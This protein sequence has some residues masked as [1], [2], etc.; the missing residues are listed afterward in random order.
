MAPAA[1][2]AGPAQK[3]TPE[4]RE[5]PVAHDRE[6]EQTEA[7]RVQTLTEKL[8]ERLRPFVEAKNPGAPGDAETVA[9]EARMRHEAEDLKV[10]SFGVEILHAIGAVY[11]TKASGFYRANAF[12]VCEFTCNIF[13]VC[14]NSMQP[15]A[16]PG[17]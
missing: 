15:C 12:G 11:V 5:K 2:L 14:G 13:C 1:L 3:V 7:A 6:I 17:F 8:V 4:Q 9:W 16:D 10:E